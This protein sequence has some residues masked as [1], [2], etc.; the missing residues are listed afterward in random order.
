MLRELS[1]G[2]NMSLIFTSLHHPR[3]V[4]HPS[5]LTSG[6]FAIIGALTRD[7]ETKI[8]LAFSVV[9]FHPIGYH[10][11]LHALNS[12]KSSLVLAGSVLLTLTLMTLPCCVVLGSDTLFTVQD[13]SYLLHTSAFSVITLVNMDHISQ[14]VLSFI[15][16][17]LT[18]E[19]MLRLRNSFGTLNISNEKMHQDDDECL[20][21]VAPGW[22]THMCGRTF[23]MLHCSLA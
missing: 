13:S 21:P 22:K 16:L 23:L 8:T 14:R 7:L 1:L 6:Q 20:A 2:Y 4:L 19:G 15:N 18:H 12:L 5:F 11:L 17:L 10:T 3:W 9:A